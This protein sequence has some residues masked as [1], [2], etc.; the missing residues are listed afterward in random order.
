MVDW[1]MM[2]LLEIEVLIH[3]RVSP[4]RHPRADAPAVREALTRL[5]N[6]GLIARQEGGFYDTTDR[7]RAHLKQLCSLPWPIKKWVGYNGEIVE[8]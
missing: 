2:T 4:T 1:P 7:G 3:C 8:Y 5:E 6:N